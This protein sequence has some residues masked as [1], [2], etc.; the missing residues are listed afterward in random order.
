M[1]W[2]PLVGGFGILAGLVLYAMLAVT[3][4][5]WLP[6]HWA[7]ELVYYAIAG[8]AWIWP[9]LMIYRW[10]ARADIDAA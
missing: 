8:L 5:D 6:A 10:A 2:R 3:V 4:A 9:A 1:R 7:V